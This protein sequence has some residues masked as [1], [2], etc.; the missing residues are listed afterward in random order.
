MAWIFLSVLPILLLPFVRGD[1]VTAALGDTVKL[2]PQINC[3]HR[4]AELIRRVSDHSSVRMAASVDGVLQQVEEYSLWLNIS[5]SGIF[6]KNVNYND[7]GHYEFTC[8]GDIELIVELKVVFISNI[9]ASEGEPRKLPCF[10]LT[11]GVDVKF[12]QWETNGQVVIKVDLFGNVV[13][14]ERFTDRV[15]LPPDWRSVG[16][17][18]LI[19]ERVQLEDQGDYYCYVQKDSKERGDPAA[20]RLRVRQERP[21]IKTF[22]TPSRLTQR[23]PA[24]KEPLCIRLPVFIIIILVSALFCILIGWCL[25]SHKSKEVKNCLHMKCWDREGRSP[26]QETSAGLFP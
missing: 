5:S 10:S 18:S 12:V 16:D 4:T 23:P 26:D 13:Y 11:Q 22:T 2:S 3:G 24:H 1:L 14:G 21:S 19:L 15:S 7:N 17:L 20:W 6:L 8:G 25:R 9:S